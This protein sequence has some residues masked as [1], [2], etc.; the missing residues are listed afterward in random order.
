MGLMQLL[1]Y[2]HG[3]TY[4]RLH[5]VLGNVW[6]QSQ[7]NGVVAGW[8]EATP[9]PRG[10]A[11]MHH[12]MLRPAV[13]SLNMGSRP[14]RPGHALW[15]GATALATSAAARPMPLTT[16]RRFHSTAP[17]QPELPA[18]P[19][20]AGSAGANRWVQSPVGLGWVRAALLCCVC[21]QSTTLW[22]ISCAQQGLCCLHHVRVML[23][24]T[25]L[26][27]ILLLS[28]CAT[29]T[30]LR[31]STSAMHTVLLPGCQLVEPPPVQRRL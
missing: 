7:G 2:G 8:A 25:P 20:W 15:A 30:V 21:T 23:Q 22:Y 18:L 9:S 31:Y 28:A 24:G 27:R 3:E 11:C 26:P 12:P 4:W 17:L 16:C 6:Q 13:A 19:H 1:P 10:E 14:E 29:S 5:Q